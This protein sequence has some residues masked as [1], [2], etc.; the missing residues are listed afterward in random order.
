MMICKGCQKE[1]EPHDKRQKFCSDSCRNRFNMKKRWLR[2]KDDPDFK[3]ESKRR[4]NEWYLKNK[5]RHNLRMRGY[6]R[7]YYRKN[8]SKA[9]R[10][11]NKTE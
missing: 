9:A 11:G 1:F 4:F 6:M 7:E 10:N 8:Y 3:E 2:L 5:K